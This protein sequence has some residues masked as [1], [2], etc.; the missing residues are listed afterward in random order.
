MCSSITQLR[1]VSCYLPI[2]FCLLSVLLFLLS[3]VFLFNCFIFLQDDLHVVHN[4][5]ACV[6]IDECTADGKAPYKMPGGCCYK[7]GESIAKFK[8]IFLN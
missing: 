4:Y 8:T 2:L 5:E 1:A 6:T 7:C 3:F